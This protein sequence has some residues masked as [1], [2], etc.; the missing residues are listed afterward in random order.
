MITLLD[1]GSEDNFSN[2]LA[3]KQQQSPLNLKKERNQDDFLHCVAL[4]IVENWAR[5]LLL[6]TPGYFLKH[7]DCGILSHN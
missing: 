5:H 1:L 4:E 3:L 7:Y 2:L 6:R